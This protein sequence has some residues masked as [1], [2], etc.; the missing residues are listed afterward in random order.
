MRTLKKGDKV[1]M[2]EATAEKWDYPTDTV[3]TIIDIL[4]DD[5]PYQLVVNATE[6]GKDWVQFFDDEE[7][8]LCQ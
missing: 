8:V 4:E 6:F 1:R 2:T 3:F 7:L 5:L